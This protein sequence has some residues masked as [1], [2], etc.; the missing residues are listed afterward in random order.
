MSFKEAEFNTTKQ[1]KGGNLITGSRDAVFLRNRFQTEVDN[2]NAAFVNMIHHVEDDER[3]KITRF[4]HQA[5]KL[6]K[7][8]LAHTDE[9][10]RLYDSLD[11][12][13]KKELGQEYIMFNLNP[14][15][16]NIKATELGTSVHIGGLGSTG[17][18]NTAPLKYLEKYP[19]L[20]AKASFATILHK[21]EEKEKEIRIAVQNFNQ[22]VA[23]FKSTLPSLETDLKKCE[24]KQKAY[25]K[26][27][28]EWNEKRKL[29]RYFNSFWFKIL[30]EDKKASLIPDTITHRIEQFTNTLNIFQSE[31]I[32]WKNHKFMQGLQN[33]INHN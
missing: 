4:I 8:I 19:E 22:E 10:K 14:Q 16:V 32:Q 33:G 30:P 6:E 12:L 31:L 29:A 18:V 5:E 25:F 28:E 24:D 7:D 3:F 20:Q 26:L 27:L 13:L 9:R 11:E 1:I 15:G 21:I 17:I 23:I 2:A